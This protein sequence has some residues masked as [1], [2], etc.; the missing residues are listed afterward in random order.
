M[1][2][3]II[4][5]PFICRWTSRLLPCPGYCKQCCNEHWVYLSFSI[6]VYSGYMSSSGIA[7]SYRSFIPSFFF[8]N[9]QTILYDSC[10]DLHSHQQCKTLAFS[11]HPLHHL[12]FVDFFDDDHFDWWEVIQITLLI[13]I[14]NNKW[15]WVFFTCLLAISMSNLEKCLFRF[16]ANF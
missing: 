1:Y 11:P 5:Y 14:S 13:C 4:S 3:W 6:M 8:R 7:R 16:S 15:C 2:Q 10:I 12:L 9:L